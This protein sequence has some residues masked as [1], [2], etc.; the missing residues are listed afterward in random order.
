MFHTYLPPFAWGGHAVDWVMW[1][2]NYLTY[3]YPVL[4]SELMSRE[5]CCQQQRLAEQQ[6]RAGIGLV[7]FCSAWKVVLWI[8]DNYREKVV[9]MAESK[10]SL[11]AKSVQKHAGRAKE[12]VSDCWHAHE[13]TLN[14]LKNPGNEDLFVSLDSIFKWPRSGFVHL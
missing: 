10:G 1:V 6:L 11:L 9:N 4:P 8:L 2:Q 3:I 14:V 12:K 5:H 7:S 13:F